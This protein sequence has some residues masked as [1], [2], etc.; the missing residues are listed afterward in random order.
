MRG[1]KRRRWPPT[2]RRVGRLVRRARV[3]TGTGAQKARDPDPRASAGAAGQPAVSTHKQA[4]AGGRTGRWDE[5]APAAADAVDRTGEEEVDTV[6]GLLQG[7]DARL[8]TLSG[9]GG[10]GKRGSR[11]RWCARLNGRLLTGCAG[12]SWLAWTVRT[13]LDRRSRARSSL[14]RCRARVRAKLYA[15][16]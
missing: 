12:S 7:P 6:C 8:V 2:S 13:M 11:S 5:H 9:P 14:R 1:A 16:T 3:R 15:V 4:G 10:V